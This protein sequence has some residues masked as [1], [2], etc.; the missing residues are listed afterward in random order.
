MCGCESIRS[1]IG[2]FA[3]CRKQRFCSAT[4]AENLCYSFSTKVYDIFEGRYTVINQC[5]STLSPKS[6]NSV[7]FRNADEVKCL[8]RSAPPNPSS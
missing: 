2:L 5:H 7:A 1:E 8:S 3:D 4:A 6:R